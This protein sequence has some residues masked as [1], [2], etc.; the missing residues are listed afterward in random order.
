M[1][2]AHA[3]MGITNAKLDALVSAS[4]HDSEH[5]S[6]RRARARYVVIGAAPHEARHRRET[7]LTIKKRRCEW[8]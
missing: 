1:K 4:G 6:G 5:V 8:R 7:K 3:G 2:S